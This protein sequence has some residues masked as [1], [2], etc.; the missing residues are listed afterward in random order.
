MTR[1]P[2]QVFE[3]MVDSGLYDPTSR[4][5]NRYMCLALQAAQSMRRITHKEY[6]ACM[7]AIVEYMTEVSRMHTIDARHLT[8]RGA[9]ARR[10]IPI[11]APG[12]RHLYAHWDERARFDQRSIEITQFI[13]TEE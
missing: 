2:A 4:R 10:G 12:L 5:A 3:Y 1:M 8:M 11:K 6:K 13:T 7:E 9:F